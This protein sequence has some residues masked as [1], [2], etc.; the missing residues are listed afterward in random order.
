MHRFAEGTAEREP[1]EV[2]GEIVEPDQVVHGHSGGCWVAAAGSEDHHTT[3]D[4]SFGFHHI[5]HI[6]LSGKCFLW[7]QTSGM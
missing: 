2:E 6:M 3:C 4:G 7:G 5:R 1:E